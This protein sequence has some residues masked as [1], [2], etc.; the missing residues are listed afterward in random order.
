VHAAVVDSVHDSDAAAAAAA[1]AAAV[2]VV[3]DNDDLVLVQDHPVQVL[4]DQ[5]HPVDHDVDHDVDVAGIVYDIPDVDDV[6]D[7]TM[8]VL[9][10]LHHDSHSDADDVVVYAH[11]VG[12]WGVDANDHGR[13]DGRNDVVVVG[14]VVGSDGVGVVVNDVVEVVGSV[15]GGHGSCGSGLDRRVLPW[16]GDGVDRGVRR[17]RSGRIVGRLRGSASVGGSAGRVRGRVL[18]GG[19][20]GVHGRCGS[21]ECFGHCGRRG[22]CVHAWMLRQGRTRR[23]R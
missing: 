21:C 15:G 22:P 1:A 14:V 17:G 3:I 19:D 11:G 2:V 12:A 4:Q 8:D 9:P 6:D 23:S 16:I 13:N 7:E 10:L 18:N 20:S 5:D